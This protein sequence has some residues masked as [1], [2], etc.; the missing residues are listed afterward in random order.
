MAE[1]VGIFFLV[2]IGPQGGEIILG[3]CDLRGGGHYLGGGFY[4]STP[5]PDGSE[6]EAP[7]VM[8]SRGS[9]M[10]PGVPGT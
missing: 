7:E 3:E 5:P 1:M 10:V 9:K 4:W 6:G 8:Q 2:E